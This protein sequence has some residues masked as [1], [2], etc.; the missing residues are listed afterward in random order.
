MKDMREAG[1]FFDGI[2]K[3]YRIGELDSAMELPQQLR[4]QMESGNEDNS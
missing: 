3:I 2:N 4:S 1:K